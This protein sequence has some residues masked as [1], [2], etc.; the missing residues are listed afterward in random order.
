MPDSI[1]EQAVAAFATRISATRALQ[2]DG[3]SDLPARACWDFSESAEKTTYGKLRISVEVNVGFMDKFDRVK[4]ASQQGNEML[5]AL[6]NDALS[7]DPT[8]GGLV[9]TINYTES[10]IDYPQPGQ[11]EIAVLATFELV[12]E[13]DN[14][15]PYS[16]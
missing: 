2:L 16:Q 14:A 5:A 10:T 6:I 3:S 8:L 4:G 7:Q 13:T 1:R 15:S 9:Q 11:D 12:Y